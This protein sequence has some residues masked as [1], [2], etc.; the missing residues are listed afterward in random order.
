MLDLFT[1][2]EDCLQTNRWLE[3]LDD[4]LIGW[5]TPDGDG[6]VGE[7]DDK[8]DDDDRVDMITDHDDAVV[9]EQTLSAQDTHD[10]IAIFED[11]MNENTISNTD[12][13]S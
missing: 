4:A 10:V 1:S 5:D 2:A 13:N 9:V 7:E 3:F 8:E 11:R 6:S 12:S